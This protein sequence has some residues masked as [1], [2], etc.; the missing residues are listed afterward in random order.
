VRHSQEGVKITIMGKEYTV[1]CPD[2]KREDLIT[3]ASY[4][5]KNMRDIKKSG[6]SL[7]NERLAVMAALNLSHDLLELRNSGGSTEEVE[8]RIKTMRESIEATLDK[9]GEIEL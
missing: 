2:E 4:L 5:D 6:T 7:G 3:A 8:K 1:A 9:Q